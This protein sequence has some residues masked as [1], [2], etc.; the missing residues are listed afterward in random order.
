MFRRIDRSVFLSRA[1]DRISHLAARQRGLPAVIGI[2]MVFTGFVLQMVTFFTPSPP[3]AFLA[4]VLN[5]LG[6]ITALVGLL[7]AQPLGK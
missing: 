6:V 1:I 5:G 3:L 7:L 2:L 4:I